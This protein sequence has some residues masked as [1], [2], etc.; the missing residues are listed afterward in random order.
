MVRARRLRKEFG[1]FVAVGGIDLD[2]RR[3]E[4]FGFLGPNGA[5]KTSTMRMIACMSPATSGELEVRG[6]TRPPKDRRSGP[7]SASS[8]R[9]TPSTP[10]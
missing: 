3:G 6:A 2:I 7:G 4:V 9:R 5:G 1:D 8:P 10:S